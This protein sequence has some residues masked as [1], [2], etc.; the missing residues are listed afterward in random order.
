MKKILPYLLPSVAD[1]F[2]VILL[3]ILSSKLGQGLLNDGD[4]GF[5]IRAG[6]YIIET[7]SIPR[8][9]MFSF[10]SP[11]PE[12]TAHEW[13]AEIVMVLVHNVLG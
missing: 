8:Q 7:F 13:L 1:V 4:T 9:D 12:W 10:L 11:S 2:F 5:H 6:E 3:I